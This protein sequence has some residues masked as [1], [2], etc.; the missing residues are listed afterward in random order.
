M[1][2]K[3]GLLGSGVMIAYMLALG[4]WGYAQLPSGAQV[5]THFG[6]DGL[7]D[8]YAGAWSVFIV[9]GMG[10]AIALLLAVIPSLEPRRANLAASAQAYTTVWLGVMGVMA[11]VETLIV[12]NA[13]H[14]AAAR[15]SFIGVAVGLLLV[16]VGTSMRNVRSNFFFGVRTPWTLSSELSWTKTHQL[17]ARAFA[18]LG[19][20]L[21][22]A[23][24]ASNAAFL[25]VTIGGIL[26]VIAL[27]IAY[28]YIV[29]RDD[30]NKH[31]IGAQPTG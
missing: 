14:V 24:L 30:P 5:P 10:I 21:M 4:A 27:L 13:M 25:A 1:D 28:S 3:I 23:S 9:P 31:S 12:L 16:V 6:L 22:A 15:P 19:I 11:A 2:R 7:P 26:A 17:A 29:W 20:A 8:G 18:V